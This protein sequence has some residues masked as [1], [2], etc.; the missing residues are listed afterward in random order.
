MELHEELAGILELL[1]QH[2]VEYA[3]CGGLAVMLHGHVRAT[4]DIDL[5]VR[6]EDLDRVRAVVQQRGFT[7]SSGKL[8]FKVGTPQEQEVHRVL[9]VEG[10]QV[11]MLDLIVV[12]PILDDVWAGREAF[13]WQGRKI[14]VVSREGLAKMKR[15]AGR[16][17]DLADLEQL[18]LLKEGV[19]ERKP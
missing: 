4:R 15:L 11:L 17:I 5:L 9:K 2:R 14:K 18:G 6:K 13:E 7:A 1:E 16:R 10:R 12:T 8:P 3:L 19:D